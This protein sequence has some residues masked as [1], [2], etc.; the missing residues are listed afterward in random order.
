M[1]VSKSF[2]EQA[3]YKFTHINKHINSFWFVRWEFLKI[4]F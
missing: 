2:G 1:A 3:S 4:E